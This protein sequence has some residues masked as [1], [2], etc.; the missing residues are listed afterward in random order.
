MNFEPKNFRRISADS[1][2]P[3]KIRDVKMPL[4]LVKESGE[5]MFANS[6]TE[7]DALVTQFNTQT[8]LLLWAWVG[9]WR[10]DV[11]QLTASDL[12]SHYK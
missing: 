12:E 3:F 5:A 6:K 1:K 2:P 10:T 11:F 4:I 8:D 7:M 9:E